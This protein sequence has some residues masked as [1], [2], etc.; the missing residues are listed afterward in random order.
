MPSNHLI[1]C[2]PLLFLPSIFPSIRV[3]PKE[4]NLTIRWPKCWSFSFSI[5]PSSEYSG[6][7]S[8]GSNWFD[9]LGVQGTLKS[10]LQTSMLIAYNR[11]GEELAVNPCT[12][13][14]W[15]PGVTVCFFP[16]A[17]SQ[18]RNSEDLVELSTSPL[19][20]PF[21]ALLPL[22]STSAP[23]AQINFNLR[24]CFLEVHIKIRQCSAGV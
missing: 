12:V 16:S 21:P 2:H 20:P 10:L 23:Q 8:F 14:N 5:G 19:F 13:T 17:G 1:L 22:S 6:L 11:K 7:I 4:P 15:R 18:F 3:F 9:L 24:L